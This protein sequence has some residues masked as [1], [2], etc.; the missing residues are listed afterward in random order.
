[1]PIVTWPFSDIVAFGAE[2]ST[3]ANVV[4]EAAGSMGIALSPDMQPEQSFF[5]RSDQYSFVKQ[6]IPAVYLDLGWGNGG[7]EAQKDFE[8][9]HYHQ[10]S[11]EADLLLYDQLARFADVNAEV[12]WGIGDMTEMPKWKKGNFFGRIFGGPMED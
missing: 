10:P 1:M 5:V 6:G 11:D 4:R 7:E 8:S 12:I 9:K 3:L 2:N